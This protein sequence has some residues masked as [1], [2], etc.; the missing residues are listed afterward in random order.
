MIYT[1]TFN[2]AIDYVVHIPELKSGSILRA[3][4]ESAYFGGKGINVSLIL[5]E[6]GI[7]SIAMGFSAGFTGKAIEDGIACEEIK[8]DFVRLKDGLTR[9]NVKIRSGEETDINGHGPEIP[10]DAIEAL[11][12]KLD[13]LQ[14]GDMLILAGSI[15][16]TLPD[17]IYERIMERLYKN[18][19]MFVV[20]AEKDLLLN[21]L[22]YKPFLIKPNKEELGEI[23]SSE[24]KTADDALK[25]AARLQDMGAVNVLISMGGE[26]AVLLDENKSKHRMSALGDE[27]VNSVGAGDSMVAGFIAGYLKEKDYA[28]ALRLGAAAGGAT[29]ASEGLGKKEKILKLL[30]S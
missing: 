1:V 3:E 15:P 12:N 28:F 10:N 20:D 26:G 29:A 5:K 23:F 21:S 9:I 2:P 27:F 17:D 8:T 11:F 30:Q 4:G 19:V 16:S 18:G 7:K 14:S 13:A 6:L 24:I 22:K 25:Y